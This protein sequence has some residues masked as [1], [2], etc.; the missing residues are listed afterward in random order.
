MPKVTIAK[1][2][3]RARGG[4]SEVALAVDMCFAAVGKAIFG[5][6]E[7]AIGLVPGGG[8]TQRLTRLLGRGRALGALGLQ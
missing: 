7:V 1:I 8:A 5:H 4:R 3:R 6:P 2:E